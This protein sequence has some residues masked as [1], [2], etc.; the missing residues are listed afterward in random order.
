M[1]KLGV[2]NKI[3]YARI[4]KTIL[5]LIYLNETI[6]EQDWRPSKKIS[7]IENGIKYLVN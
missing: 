6:R 4:E 2:V 3:K 7:E 1:Q 5:K